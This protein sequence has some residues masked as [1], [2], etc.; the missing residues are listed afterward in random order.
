[1]LTPSLS[2][3]H[4]IIISPYRRTTPHIWGQAA[5]L[6]NKPVTTAA[7]FRNGSNLQGRIDGSAIVSSAQLQG[8]MMPAAAADGDAALPSSKYLLARPNRSGVYVPAMIR[9]GQT[10]DPPHTAGGGGGGYHTPEPSPANHSHA[11]A[12]A[13]S[14]LSATTSMVVEAAGTLFLHRASGGTARCRASF[15]CM[16]EDRPLFCTHSWRW[17]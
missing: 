10:Y 11:L 13:S 1:M 3:Y 6:T 5:A 14:S 4:S 8:S 17:W 7:S 12:C 2:W 16:T 15:S 9:S